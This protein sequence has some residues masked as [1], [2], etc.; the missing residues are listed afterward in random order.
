[1]HAPI[2]LLRHLFPAAVAWLAL[3]ASASV[4]RGADADAFFAGDHIS[5]IEIRLA[6]GAADRLR[7]DPRSYVPCTLTIDADAVFEDVAI[8]LK[9]AAGS[10]QGL[11]DKPGFTVNIDRFRP[12]ARFHGLDRFHLN[13]AAQDPSFLAEWLG[14]H[15]FLEAGVPA[16]RVTHARV[17]LD[18]RD[19]GLY[20]F[21]EA[22]DRDFLQRHFNDSSGNLY[23][24]G[25]GVDLDELV[26][27]D[28]GKNGLP[29]ADLKALVAACRLADPAQR[30]AAI[31]ARLDVDAFVTFMALEL[32]A[33][34]WDG[35][36]IGHNNYRIYVDP[37][38]GDR[39]RFLPHGMDQ[40]FGDP[41]APILDRPPTIVAGAVMGVPEWRGAYR[42]RLRDL[43][44]LFAAEGAILPRLDSVAERIRPAVAETG[45]EALEAWEGAWGELRDRI[46]AREGHLREQAEAPE[47]EPIQ[48]DGARRAGLAGWSPRTDA[49][50]ATH[51]ETAGDDG[52]SVLRI[53]VV[54]ETPAIASWRVAVPLPAGRYRFEGLAF[55]EGIEA[56]ADD[57]GSGAGLRISGG[58]RRQ[59]VDRAGEWTPLVYEFSLEAAATVELVAELRATAGQVSFN[60]ESLVLVRLSA[61]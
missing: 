36:T 6:E 48:F 49:G 26:E 11:D 12:G 20:V 50:E 22:I 17:L 29:G 28:E 38:N 2:P 37:A 42:D 46:V 3:A 15:L 40:I 9:G 51:D 58:Q 56:T 43:L 4:T 60:A 30:Q 41:G 47:P 52:R 21:K 27:R 44:P 57:T 24:G 16:A 10:F 13:N 7:D 54:G 31:S 25:T 61:P 55:G 23:D 35:S 34:H 33:G 8:K 18:D 32:M 39:I 59:A 45:G 1:M 5:R 14:A 19:L 53:N